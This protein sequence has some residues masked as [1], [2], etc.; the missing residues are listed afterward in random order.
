V[1]LLSS[2]LAIDEAWID[3]NGH[4]NMAYYNV[5]FDRALDE[6]LLP[7]GLGPDYVRE[8]G[9][10]YM[11]VE[12]HI[13]YLREVFRADTVRVSVRVLD[14]DAKRMHLYC[15]MRHAIEDWLAAT[16]EWMF[17]HVDTKERRSAPWPPDIRE[18]LD[19]IRRAD[20]HLAPPARAGRRIGIPRK[21]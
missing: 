14:L 7:T 9:C 6:V 10:T 17:L 21:T 5:L 2:P 18:R 1:P 19:A 4:L 15:E 11:A 12:A 3:Y 8:T 13:C 16:S 20:E